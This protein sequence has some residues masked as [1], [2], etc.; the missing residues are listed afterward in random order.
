MAARLVRTL[1]LVIGTKV[2]WNMTKNKHRLAVDTKN[3]VVSL[4]PTFVKVGQYVSTRGDIFPDELIHEFTKLQDDVMPMEWTQVENII[5]QENLKNLEN[6][7][8][9]PI[10]SAS[11]GQVHT[12]TYDGKNS[13]IKILRPNVVEQIENDVK[14]LKFI[15]N[16]FKIFNPTGANDIIIFV[17]ELEDMLKMETDYKKESEN[18]K[19]FA[20]NF[21]DVDWVIVPDVYTATSNAIVMEYVPSTKITEADGYDKKT[22]TYAITKAQIMQVLNSGFFHGDPHPGNVG[23][24]DGKLVYY[25]FGMISQITIKQKNTLLALL[26]A[27]TSENEDQILAILNNLGLI[28]K[29]PTGL[30]KF[31]RFFLE[32]IRKN[33][34]QDPEQI[35]ELAAIQNNPV[36]LSGS[37]FYLIRSFA[38]I[39]GIS[40]TLDPDYSSAEAL[41]KYAEESELMESA[42]VMSI[43]NTFSD[44]SSVSYRL[45]SIEKRVQ[46]GIDE[47][48]M[49]DMY[50]IF[51]MITLLLS[52]LWYSS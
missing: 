2:K 25:D 41:Q 50:I 47:R 9:K 27:I 18:T 48:K 20:K 49:K 32:Y 44:M 46:K 33:Q 6:I 37:F 3:K 34:I 8:H 36:K 24:K 12:C 21:Q 31:V 15:S 29:D 42:M 30:R 26:I 38:L 11:L 19:I 39:E 43:R 23:I 17:D 10:A 7:S 22:L 14:N 5:Y 51:G 16:I 1:D 40:K 4:G 45:S 13:V 35:K 52:Q 28:A